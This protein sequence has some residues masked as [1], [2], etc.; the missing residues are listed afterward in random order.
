M[1]KRGNFCFLVESEIFSIRD[2]KQEPDSSLRSDVG[3]LIMAAAP[4]P[5]SAHSVSFLPHTIYLSSSMVVIWATG[6]DGA[7]MAPARSV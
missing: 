1:A 4:G 6:L 2:E 5:G 7:P 3:T